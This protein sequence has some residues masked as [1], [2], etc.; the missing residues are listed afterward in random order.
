MPPRPRVVPLWLALAHTAATAVIV[1]AYWRAYGPEHFLWFSHVA[2]VLT[3]VAL[4]WQQRL[5]ASVMAVMVALPELGWNLDFFV[6]LIAGDPVTGATGYMFDVH[7]PLHLRLM[8]LFHVFLPFE[9]LWLLHRLGY[10]RRALPATTVLAWILLPASWLATRHTRD[11]IN[12]VL[13]IHNE[14]DWMPPLVYLGLLMLAFPLL[15]YV[16][17][18]LLFRWWFPTRREG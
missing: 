17:S 18:H 11:N 4:W 15:I 13:G 6:S 2:L 7:R 8:S 5:V 9:L 12:W 16:P 1:V 14:Q 3:T 10:D